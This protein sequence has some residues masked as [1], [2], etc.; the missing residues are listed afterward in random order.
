MSAFVTSYV[1]CWLAV[2]LY[3]FQLGHRQRRI[4]ERIASLQA[5]M[6]DARHQQVEGSQSSRKLSRKEMFLDELGRE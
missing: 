2:A 1:I 3:V 5:C 6:Q 4:S